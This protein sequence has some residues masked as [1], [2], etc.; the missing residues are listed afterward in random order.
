ML[1][2]FSSLGTTGYSKRV[3]VMNGLQFSAFLRDINVNLYGLT[4]FE[5]ECLLGKRD[6]F[7]LRIHVVM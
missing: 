7:L 6:Y 3:S 5:T 2:F 4:I 1:V